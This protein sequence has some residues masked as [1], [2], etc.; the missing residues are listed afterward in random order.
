MQTALLTG[1]SKAEF[2]LLIELAKKL[3][4]KT[5]L[6]SEDELE[7]MGLAK[8]MKE[9]RTGEFVNTE[10]FLKRLKKK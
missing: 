8:A 5:T 9:G 2:S 1:S 10:S 7:D 4:I 6:L 3:G